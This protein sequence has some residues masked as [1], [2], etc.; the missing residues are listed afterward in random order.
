MT[1]PDGI[2]LYRD[3][4]DNRLWELIYPQSEMHG[5]GPPELRNLTFNEARQKYDVG[6][7]QIAFCLRAKSFA[8]ELRVASNNG[9]VI[10]P[11]VAT[12]S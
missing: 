6:G 8:Q 7:H 11:I 4:N 1:K 3:P 12:H 5:G 2:A 9:C 10:L